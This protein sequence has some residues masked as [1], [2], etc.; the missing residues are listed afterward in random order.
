MP[1]KTNLNIGPY[2]D[3]FSKDKNFYKVL[4]RPGYPV[5]ARELT[6][7]QSSLHNQLESFGSHMFKEGSMVIPGN[8][9]Y[10]NEYY[11]LRLLDN[12]L[13]IPISLY[14]SHLKGKRLK[15]QNSGVVVSV[16]DYKLVS[17]AS[18]IT[19]ITLF[20][21]YV[22]SG[23]DNKGGA[24][25][26]GEQLITEESF[27]YGNTAVNAGD[28]VVTLVSL[29]AAATGSSAGI[30]K[31]VYFIRGSFVDVQADKI[32]LDPYTNTPSYR[33]GLSINEE[34][35]GSK[36]DASL[37]DNARGFSNYAAPGADRLKISTTLSKK[38]LNDFDDKSFIEILR[39][40][41][42]EIKKIQNES[43]YNLIKDYF[44]KRTFEESGN[45]SLGNFQLDVANSLNDGVD[46]GIFKS[47]QQTDDGNTPND[48]LMCVKVSPG[49]A[50]VNGY[51]IN[52]SFTTIVDVKKPR[53]TK[54][55]DKSLVPFELGTRLKVNNVW[56][57]PQ[58]ALKTN[59]TLSLQSERRIAGAANTTSGSGQEIGQAR[60][61][62][63]N[64]SD[65]PYTNDSSVW[66]LY[67]FDVQTYTDLELNIALSTA[68]LPAS[69]HIKGVQS[70]ATGYAV[71][72][73]G[74]KFSHKFTQTSG[75]F[76][77]GERII[78]NAAPELS[79]SIK[80][81][82]VYGT[83]D[84][85][86]VY[87]NTS[88]VAGYTV[89]FVADTELQREDIPGFNGNDQFQFSAQSGGSCTVTCPG[90]KFT[91][92]S[93]GSIISFTVAGA[94]N[95]PNFN[96]VT[97]IHANGDSMTV[98]AGATV[99]GI[100]T[101]NLS[102]VAIAGV[103]VS[104]QSP[105][106]KDSDT[107]GLFT[108][109]PNKNIS[110][111]DLGDSNLLV[112][113]HL[114]GR[115]VNGSG[116][117]SFDL[118]AATGIAT[119][120]FDTF[121]AERYAV[122]YN[123][124]RTEPL[125]SDQFT[126]A[127][128][129]VTI[130]GLTASSS[131]VVV[132]SSI[133][134]DSIKN[135]QKEF[136]RS[137]KVS[138]TKVVGAGST[139]LSGLLT[140][141][142]YGMRIED[143]E[144]SLNVADVVKV[145]A[146]YESVNTSAPV[147]DKLTYVSGL[148]LANSSILGERLRGATSGA[149]AQLATRSSATEVEI[150]YL[151]A[152]RF[153]I[154]EQ[155]TFEESNIVTNLQD[156]TKGSYVDVTNKFT[157]DKGHREQYYDYS[158]LVRKENLSVPS[159]QLLVV[160]DAYEVPS[161]DNGD[162]YTADS[163]SQERYT[164]DIPLVGGHRAT[165]I[166]DF[167]PR[168]APFVATN[169][170]PFGYASRDF[171]VGINPTLVVSP[172]ESSLLGYSF[173]LPRI[174]KLVLTPGKDNFGE[175]SLIKGVSAVNPKEPSGSDESMT[176]ATIDLP[177]YLYSPED[178]VIK[179]IDNRRYTMR[180]IGKIEDRVEN[181]EQF[182]SLSLLELSAKT[183]QVQD[184]NGIDRFKSG[185]FADDFKDNTFL[186]ILDPDCKAVVDTERKE[187]NTP[188]NLF[189]IKP[190]LALDGSIN[191]D[192]ADFSANLALLDS[193]VQKT[194]DLITL[195]YDEKE[196]ITQKLA[197]KVENVNPFNIV[198]FNG[199]LQ[200]SPESD[201]WV[202]NIEVASATGGATLYGDGGDLT[203][204]N[205]IS[206]EPDPHIRSR[207]ISFDATGLK[208]F[209]RY[210]PFFDSSAGIDIIPKLLSVTMTS[211]SFKKGEDIEIWKNNVQVGKFRLCQNNH[212][213]GDIN[214]PTHTF[215][216]NPY[217]TSI[218]VPTNYSSSATIL[219][220]DINGLSEDAQGNYYGYVPSGTGVKI[221]GKT[222]QAEAKLT[223][224]NLIADT[225]GDVIGSF[226]FRNPAEAGAL[227][228]KNGVKTFKLTSSETNAKSI[229]GSVSNSSAEAT[230]T[231]N[232]IINTFQTTTTYVQPLPP[233]KP[234]KIIYE[235][236]EIYNTELIESDLDIGDVIDQIRQDY[237]LRP[238]PA[239]HGDPLSQ[240]FRVDETGAF[241]TSVDVF[242][243]KKDPKE[244]I[245]FEVR[246]TEMGTPTETLVQPYA[247]VTY[248]P[249]QI[250]VS[251]DASKATKVTF[252]S[253]IYLETGGVFAF[254]MLAETTNN[255]EAWVAEMGQPNISTD[256]L[257][258]SEKSI[259]GKQYLGGSLFKSQNGT[260]WT[261]SQYE[262]LKFT[263]NKAAF[264][265]AGD[266]TFYNP[267]LSNKSSITPRLISNAV[268]TLPRKL[269]VGIQTV[270]D[271]VLAANLVPGIKVSDSTSESAVRGYIERVAS[272]VKY[273]GTGVTLTD[274]GS[275]Y[276][277]GSNLLADTYAITG[278]GSGA[279]VVLTISGGTI[280]AANITGTGATTGN[281]YVAGDLL[282]IS[283]SS[284]TLGKGSEGTVT[285]GAI[286]GIDTLYLTNVQGRNFTDGQDLVWYPSPGATA[287]GWA[288]TH[289]RDSSVV[290][291]DLYKGNVVEVHHFNHGMAADN[292]LVALDDIEPDTVPIK[293]TGNIANTSATTISV[294]NTSEFHT[295]E[296]IT[297]SIGYL[298]VNQEIIKYDGINQ[299]NTLTVATGGRGV[300][301]SIPSTHGIGDLAYKYE[302][303]G[304][305]LIGINTTHDMADNS[306]IVNGGKDIDKYYLE[307]RQSGRL[308][309]K[310]RGSTGV[311]DNDDN[312]VCF[313]DEKSAGGDNIFASQ[314][315]QFNS[316][317]PR[318]NMLT[319][320]SS[321][322][323][324]AQLRTVSGTSAS[325]NESSFV[326]QGYESIELNKINE[327]NSTRM[328]CSEINETNK[329]S[330]LPKNRSSTLQ[331]RLTSSDS[332]LSP[333]VDYS[334]MVMIY[335]R[336]LL[337][338]PINDYAVD[339]ASNNLD[340]DPHAGIY[341]SRKID[342]KQPATS[343]QVVVSAYRHSSA[344]FRVLYRLFKPDSKEVNESY[345]LFP[346][347]DNL[348]DTDG[349]G[350]GDTVINAK[351]N[352]GRAD[353]IVASNIDNEFSEYQFSVDNLD[354]FTGFA[355]KIVMDG[356]NEAFAPRFKDLRAIALA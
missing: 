114:T 126:L 160:Y 336:N 316:I 29:D 327:F 219:N 82:R 218:N 187:L 56:G 195:K 190:E 107:S 172:N 52:K 333:I 332:N 132:T 48:N 102:Q 175:F 224:L 103:Q 3:D 268:K 61:Y 78:I 14:I 186:D 273:D 153:E 239:P 287:V 243:A 101:G 308:G 139:I 197:S 304:I 43:Q 285:V 250:N 200:L 189:S 261:P 242:F 269:K 194:G 174:D 96:K 222:S 137:Q 180:D 121:D 118:T 54:T 208:P 165:D 295:Y 305:S 347:Y 256:N 328:V 246:L 301:G 298:K 169:K 151:N 148:D 321:T 26:D 284:A 296:G 302:L 159:R 274:G 230:Y 99:V 289:I 161:N 353:A 349:D 69:S 135:K 38:S 13:G 116:V 297:T 46:E 176:I 272:R 270:T 204:K 249:S 288:L 122:H 21:S 90:K 73:G 84:I 294:A 278:N 337:N 251:D 141:D 280:T 83:K 152:E 341:I 319:P 109:L 292:N 88:A 188:I 156:L 91:G 199:W 267:S 147:L 185:F 17:D 157:L 311:P 168:V 193:K 198:V 343:L 232:G 25:E 127:N 40:D 105:T 210:Y 255:Y 259:I 223:N 86:S 39:I 306:S 44:A 330:S 192:T 87:Q 309:L 117:M 120:F 354:K 182:T 9:S 36:D 47:T 300:K 290:V 177:A 217:D 149:V 4:F 211:G 124:G 346:G 258:N 145:V 33:I 291:N 212:K 350:F 167:R 228:F 277:N 18:D 191:S 248:E 154:G 162:V 134:K 41:G 241:L 98:G 227:K 236:T 317:F 220:I 123:D 178:S 201:S 275:G 253:P 32:I 323:I 265:Q 293:L 136:V 266:L 140:S 106:I 45:Y 146:V 171:S 150:V 80:T 15:G 158:R 335:E 72:D 113:K 339:S 62:S 314:N 93:T 28:T 79:A 130:K 42:G 1:Q 164:K 240:T 16:D 53:D 307:V 260:I 30:G 128:N 34:I 231:T 216:T 5:Q 237:I 279:K 173:Y 64:L 244:K 181:L 166:L 331:L 264:I 225:F 342:L 60:I 348:K 303:N 252:P 71:E 207:N 320:G 286:D 22:A 203:S 27:V 344:D 202:T 163:Y 59:N 63:V 77:Q 24:L 283:T 329:L 155:I 245:R 229:A 206:S 179:S 115:S 310:D 10:N 205:L 340:G 94:H 70:G 92:I 23:D 276:T 324:S 19:D 312:L 131:D 138:V 95:V 74:G 81:V 111:V 50:Y 352:S 322:G 8:I 313:V 326:D 238:K 51:D 100:C 351:L 226:F 214:N 315:V 76:L 282:G 35:I 133:R 89:D 75:T 345:T 31:G 108:P 213:Y 2:Y 129:S 170:S 215:T 7:L 68:Q 97:S 144:I 66:D 6:T 143:R 281:G 334:N 355:I 57:I 142:Y 254:V 65:A 67:L 338:Q 325:G 37:Y 55:I 209:T 233:P 183:L 20:I 299:G 125:T 119:G 356:T 318:V 234:P 271:A 263:L 12:H 49:K 85:K 58:L 11:S 235:V 247:T 196:W 110:N 104:L 112:T 257:P 262:D 221:V 184:A